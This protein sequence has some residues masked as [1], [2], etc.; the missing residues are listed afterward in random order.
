MSEPTIDNSKMKG[1]QSMKKIILGVTLIM[2]MAVVVKADYRSEQDTLQ[3][4]Y[5]SALYSKTVLIKY[6]D[7]NQWVT[8]QVKESAIIG[9]QLKTLYEIAP[10]K[11]WKRNTPYVNW[12][13]S[14]WG[15]SNVMAKVSGIIK[16]NQS[17][18]RDTHP[19]HGYCAKLVTH[20]ET[21]KVLGIVNIKVLAAGSI[22]LGQML[23]PITSTSNPMAKL[24]A[25]MRFTAR[26][27]ALMFDYKVKLAGQPNRIKETGFSKVKTVP[28]I[29][30]CDCISL[31]QK[32]WEDA[33]GNLYAK[34]VGTMVVRFDNN[35]NGWVEDA[36]FPIHYGDITHQ[37]FYK[38]YM[39]LITGDDTKWAKNSKG[40][41]VPVKEI[42]WAHADDIPTHLILQFDS[43]HGGA[44]IG[45]IGNTL[46]VDNVRMAY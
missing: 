26:P 1:K 2:G 25:G 4:D 46:W 36:S 21:C 9:G 6:G 16:T 32:R 13:G 17:V 23:E 3:T 43:S 15:T 20:I 5:D 33:K 19:G 40:K 34:R 31:L 18:Y 41:M 8:R 45:S 42:G 37:P 10:A 30:M 7:M 35:T 38:P 44:Y 39:G 12:A 28:G 29:D 14:P 27:K 22:Y 11:A 24:D